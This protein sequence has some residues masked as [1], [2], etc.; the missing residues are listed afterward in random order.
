MALAATR[1]TTFAAGACCDDAAV[2]RNNNGVEWRGQATMQG[3]PPPT[4]GQMQGQV[5][6]RRDDGAPVRRKAR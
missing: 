2:G 3:E 6:A 1:N 5:V 4:S